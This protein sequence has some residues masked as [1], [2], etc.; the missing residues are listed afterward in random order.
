MWS[1]STSSGVAALRRMRYD[2][3]APLLSTTARRTP[4]SRKCFPQASAP[5]CEES[6]SASSR[7]GMK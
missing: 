2:P 5:C 1:T 4:S 7:L 3:C 6:S